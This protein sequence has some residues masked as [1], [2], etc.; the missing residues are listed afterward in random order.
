MPTMDIVTIS[1]NDACLLRGV[2]SVDGQDRVRGGAARFEAR[3][4][5]DVG[6]VRRE[7]RGLLAGWEVGERHVDD[8]V[9]CLSE[10]VTNSVVHARGGPVAV[11]VRRTGA[12]VRVEVAD[13]DARAPRPAIPV[14]ATGGVPDVAVLDDHGRGLFL[15]AVL[16][17]RWGVVP[18]RA[19]KRL[20]F[21]IDVPAPVPAGAAR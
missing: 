3:G 18:A 7:V 6:V 4:P 15:L 1:Q 8:V 12:G 19:G 13:G 14:E 11:C 16:A 21:E 20:W 9:T 5:A 2:R 10:A 17:T